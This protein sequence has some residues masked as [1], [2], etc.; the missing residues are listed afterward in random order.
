LNVAFDREAGVDRGARRAKGV[1]D[2]AG[3]GIMQSAMGDRT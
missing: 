1:F 3:R 2:H